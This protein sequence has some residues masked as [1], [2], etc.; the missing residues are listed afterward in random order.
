[1]VEEEALGDDALRDQVEWVDHDWAAAHTRIDNQS[2]ELAEHASY[3]CTGLATDSV[4]RERHAILTDCCPYSLDGA[5]VIDNHE[6][7]ADGLKFR[8]KLRAPHEVN[9]FQAPCF[10]DR[11]DR[12][13][14]ARV[15]RVLHHPFT[16]LQ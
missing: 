4:D 16:R 15:G 14:N 1:M 13:A 2:A 12:P 6:I 11:D 10:S 3:C 9:R 5:I 7:A 8:N